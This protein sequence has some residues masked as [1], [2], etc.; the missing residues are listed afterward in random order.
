MIA[1]IDYGIGNLKSVHNAFLHLGADAR[2]ISDPNQLSG[3][4]RIV[5]PGVGAFEKCIKNLIQCGFKEALDY[6]VMQK[7]VPTLGICVG[8]QIMAT[9][10]TENGEW[11]G[12]N[13]FNGSVD[14]ISDNDGSLRIPNIGWNEVY[15]KN[16]NHPILKNLPREIILYFVHSYHMRCSENSDVAL[17]YNYGGELT[18]AIAKDNIFATQ[19]HPEKSQ[20]TGL[21]II[22]NFI[23]WIP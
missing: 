21:Q 19:F 20:D 6:Y 5:I 11:E 23:N 10:G 3:S 2:L 18:A 1:I 12:L 8:M 13:W 22:D 7:A 16:I 15:I 4:E 14:K 9:L 17:A